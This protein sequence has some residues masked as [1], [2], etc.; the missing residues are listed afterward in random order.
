MMR[1]R[2]D[3]LFI[4]ILFVATVY[5]PG[6]LRGADTTDESNS[7]NLSQSETDASNS[8]VDVTAPDDQAMQEPNELLPE[9]IV[10]LQNE[11]ETP[12]P[13]TTNQT[14]RIWQ[15]QYHPQVTPR[16]FQVLCYPYYPGG[17]RYPLPETASQ[18][19]AEDDIVLIDP[20]QFDTALNK[21]TIRHAL[22]TYCD[23]VHQWRTI[24][25]STDVTTEVI[26]SI[27][28]TRRATGI[29]HLNAGLAIDVKRTLGRIGRLN[30][31]FDR[32]S[33]FALQN[34]LYHRHN[35]LMSARLEKHVHELQSLFEH[36]C[37]QNDAITVKLGIGKIDRQAKRADR[38]PIYYT[39]LGLPSV[40]SQLYKEQ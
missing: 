2:F 8:T 6:F 14:T 36:L 28:L 39:N 22:E 21:D 32:T 24:N 12:P 33:R 20:N 1:K 10:A 31:T 3:I 17:Y 34:L 27:E 35:K 40:P 19:I 25:E 5:G 15:H 23:L 7:S 4:I 9:Q 38:S 30:Q 13:T 11:P 26:R 37:E 16:I 18:T 29:Y